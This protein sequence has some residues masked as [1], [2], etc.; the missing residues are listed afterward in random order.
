M[1]SPASTLP[2]FLNVWTAARI[3]DDGNIALGASAGI[4]LTTGNNNIDIG[5]GGV[6]GESGKIRIGESAIQAATYIA[7]I[8]GVTLN[9][10][11]SPIVIDANDQ[12]G[13]VDINTLIGPPGPQGPPGPKVIR[14]LL[15]PRDR[16]ALKDQR[17]RRDRLE[18]VSLSW[19]WKGQ[20]RVMGR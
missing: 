20:V 9:A 16:K 13:V 19:T 11:I 14:G 1:L 12:L 18:R 4:N 8:N 2:V 10:P 7:G 15:G 17:D 5:N 3:A 6:A